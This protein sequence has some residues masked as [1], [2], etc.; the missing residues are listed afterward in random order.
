M[1]ERRGL[2]RL[3][4]LCSGPGKLTQALG[5]RPRPQ[6]A[7]TCSGRP[8]PRSSRGPTAG[9]ASTRRRPADRDHQGGRAAVALLRGAAAA[10]S[11]GRGRRA[12]ATR[13]ARRAGA[14]R[15]AGCP[16]PVPPVVRRRGPA[17]ASVRRCRRRRLLTARAR[18]RAPARRRRPCRCSARCRAGLA[19]SASSG[20]QPGAAA[21]PARR[22]RRPGA[23]VVVVVVVLRRQA[24]LGLARPWR[25]AASID[26]QGLHHEVVPDLGG[27]GAA[28]RPARRRTRSSSASARRGSRPTP[29]RCS[30]LGEADEPGVAVVL[31]RAGLARGELADSGAPVPVPDGTTVGHDLRLRRRRRLGRA[32]GSRLR[33]VLR[34]RACVVARRPRPRRMPTGPSSAAPSVPRRPRWPP[35]GERLVGVGHVERGDALLEAA[36]RHRVVVSRPACGCP[37]AGPV[38]ATLLGADLDADLGVDA[39]CRSRSSRRRASCEPE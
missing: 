23:V 8:D 17:P 5:H 24:R 30:L 3:E 18:A 7:P 11:R 27:V 28:R 6:R 12:C 21:P 16:P 4:D 29:R 10:T 9:P 15:C 31:G 36:E 32:R 26:P 20:R 1:R 25:R 14:C 37:C 34:S 22:A 38:A 19:S 39:S 2:E 33:L 13:S 35:R